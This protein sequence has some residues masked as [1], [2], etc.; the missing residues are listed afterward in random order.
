VFYCQCLSI[1]RVWPMPFPVHFTTALIKQPV[2]RRRSKS[3]SKS[4]NRDFGHVQ[5]PAPHMARSRSIP[6]QSG[7]HA[8]TVQKSNPANWLAAQV[9]PPNNGVNGA[10]SLWGRGESTQ[11]RS[12][13]P[14]LRYTS[15]AMNSSFKMQPLVAGGCR[16]A[17]QFPVARANV[18]FKW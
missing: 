14:C 12:S 13:F 6:T 15:N 18:S 4:T 5:Y 8:A 9:R 17:I 16:Q 11:R 3:F 2:T 7:H 1:W 10:Q